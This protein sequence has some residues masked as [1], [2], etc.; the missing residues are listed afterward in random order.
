MGEY[1]MKKLIS[2]TVESEDLNALAQPL[3][4]TYVAPEQYD[5]H[6]VELSS[7]FYDQAIELWERLTGLSD[8][9]PPLLNQRI[10]LPKD[11]TERQSCAAEQYIVPASDKRQ[12]WIS[13]SVPKKLEIPFKST[14]G[15]KSNLSLVRKYLIDN[16]LETDLDY[17]ACYLTGTVVKHPRELDADHICSWET[18]KANIKVLTEAMNQYP[19]FGQ[20]II[21]EL[22]KHAETQHFFTTIEDPKTGKETWAH[23]EWFHRVYFNDVSN[24]ILAKKVENEERSSSDIQDYLKSERGQRLYLMPEEESTRLDRRGIITRS[25]DGRGLG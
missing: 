2:I 9:L 3:Q 13:Q 20:F 21:Q 25:S 15:T 14:Y 4:A 1:A 16:E 12:V 18:I 7:D 10:V 24:I 22:D 19:E 8:A 11:I 23:T 17:F 5:G 6:V